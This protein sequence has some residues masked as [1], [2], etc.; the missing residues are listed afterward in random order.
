MQKTLQLNFPEYKFNV[1]ERGQNKQIFDSIRRKYVALTP[2]EWVRQNLLQFLVTEKKYPPM[3]ISVETHINLNG[4]SRRCDAVVNGRNGKPVMLIECKAP[5]E[6][7]S[8]KT[9]DQ[10]GR[11]NLIT[12]VKWLLVS[13]GINHFCAETDAANQRFNFVKEIPFYEE[14]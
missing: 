12:K 10:A 9:F 4:L 6:T 2:E 1:V 14:L 3:L 5:L 11:Y 13:N 7:I 8:Q